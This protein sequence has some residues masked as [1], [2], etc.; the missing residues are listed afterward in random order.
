MQFVSRSI[1]CFVTH[2][3]RP[4]ET[5]CIGFQLM[6]PAGFCKGYQGGIV[7]WENCPNLHP[8]YGRQTA[9]L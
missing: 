3:L 9:R 7:K 8:T 5:V 1:Q 6:K 4:T 2:D